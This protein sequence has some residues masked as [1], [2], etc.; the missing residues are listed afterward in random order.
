MQS[1]PYLFIPIGHISLDSL[2]T[3]K[4]LTSSS[5]H[6]YHI[7]CLYVSRAL[8]GAGIGWATMDAVETLAAKEPLAATALTLDTLAREHYFEVE[9]YR[10]LGRE[11]PTV[12]CVMLCAL[13]N[14]RETLTDQGADVQSGLV[15]E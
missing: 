12:C 9:R 14:W 5:E 6:T 8:Q 3:D 11:P 13:E 4:D 10:A 7:T 15:C 1:P 2:S